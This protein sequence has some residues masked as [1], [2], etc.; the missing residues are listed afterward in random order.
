MLKYRLGLDIGAT[1]LGWAVFD[2]DKQKVADAGV[3]IFDD[4]R[5]DKTKA[6]LCVK[7]RAA[8]SARR[9][10]NRK[11]IKKRYLLETL[12][13]Y[14]L[15]PKEP[16][17]QQALKSL[18]PYQLRKEALDKQLTPFEIGRIFFHLAQRKG[19]L[20]NRKDNKEEGGKLKEGYHRLKEKMAT[21][22]ARTYGEYL[23]MS[24]QQDPAFPMRLKNTFDAAGKFIGADFPF[25]D[26]YKEEFHQIFDKQR[27]F[28]P[29]ILTDDVYDKL[30]DILFFQRPLREAQEGY[31]LFEPG[32]R[33]IAKAHP[34]F[35]EQRMWQHVLNLRFCP[36]NASEYEMLSKE[37]IERLIFILKHPAQFLK[38]KSSVL[39]YGKIKELLGLD[40][41][42]IFNFEKKTD[43]DSQKGVLVDTTAHAIGLNPC[44]D[45]VWQTFSDEQ[46]EKVVCVL[47]RPSEFI[48]FPKTKMSIEQQDQL[49]INYL[50]EHFPLPRPAAEALLFEVNLEDGFGA[51]SEKALRR[52]IPAMQQGMGYAD[53]CQAAG[54][55]HCVTAYAH[56]DFLPYYGEI[57][58][59]S[60]IGQK[61]NTGTVEE[62]YGKINNATVHVALNQVRHVVNALIRRYGK[63]FDISI[64]YARDLPASKEDR[65]KMSD[66]RDKNE[67]ENQRILKELNEKI[68][69]RSWTKRDIEKYKIW[70]TLGTPKGESALNCRECP[71]TGEKISVA[72]LMNG[73]RF[74]IEHLI[75]F[76]RSLDNSLHNKVIALAGANKYKGNRTPYEAFHDS[77]NGFDWAAIQR[78]AKKLSY[79]QQWRFGKNAMAKF[80]EKE[81]PI[82]RSLNDTRY[83]TRLLQSYLRPIVQ[84]E[85][86]QTVQAVAGQL[87]A[88]VRKAWGLNQYK[89][90][91]NKEGNGYR[92][93]HNHHAVDAIIVAAIERGQIS[94]VARHLKKVRYSAIEEFKEEFYKF[95]DPAIS[96]EEKDALK[97]RIKDFV[98]EREASLVREYIPLPS[99]VTV[100]DVLKR[101]Q[102]ICISHKP[103]LKDVKNP[104]ATVGQLHE[105]SAYGLKGF[106]D[107]TSL[108]ARFKCGKKVTKKDV[109]EY[110]PMFHEKADK[111]A[112]YDAFKAWFMVERK[113][114]TLR[115]ATAADKAVKK[116]LAAQEAVAVQLLRTAAQKAF[117][118]F[119]GGGNF[120]AEI[121]EIN[122]QNKIG[123]VP[124]TDAG[125]WKSEVISNYN[126]TVRVS[127][128]E[129]IFYWRNRYPN[130][131]RVMT[132]KRNDM[133]LGTFT[134]EQA[135]CDDFPLGIQDYVRS[136]FAEQP[137]AEK[138]TVL[139]RVK[140]MRGDGRVSL[141]PHDIAK[142]KKDEKTWC[143]HAVSLQRYAAQ[144]VTVSPIGR[145][146]HAK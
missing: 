2:M 6:S 111:Q 113:A 116:E 46:K 90:K 132:L 69:E 112:Y 98:K 99:G 83:M 78:R 64:E 67:L 115:A 71:F 144:K 35:Q 126:A 118:W 124:T 60:C 32:E 20:S 93:F 56:L 139:F 40:K 51:L 80:E 24:R 91:E 86:K 61:S 4:G 73:D 134:K 105:D 95:K 74:Q 5:E 143:A 140:K 82:A 34:L 135:F 68:G 11:H 9:L 21:M 12:V 25:R 39:S 36:E 49:I 63:P 26:I 92:D 66:T 131:R 30:E 7:R 106:V 120:C 52:I 38:T 16:E 89:D 14:G 48:A 19:F 59:Q 72:D 76:S 125:V 3:R 41:K 50:C 130:A 31:C 122:P 62:K 28:Y 22:G 45:A 97:N 84:E 44:V 104:C 53:A 123:G 79:E 96:K 1:S 127:R 137:L 88:M 54:Y 107:E 100:S 102:N 87:T 121:Y 13:Q 17:A 103:K 94:A 75:P 128:G 145:I 114:K 29:D 18:N 146:Q 15:F 141:T 129:D 136:K 55:H 10:Q 85:G 43:S 101:V 81:G 47:S 77:L 23:Y 58:S 109:T 42:G 133:V 33:R 57:L 70:K 37:Q 138:I 65:L 142:E 108:T 27:S 119:V 8:R 110:I 117:K